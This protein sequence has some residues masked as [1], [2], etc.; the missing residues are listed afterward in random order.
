MEKQE[1]DKFK[2]EEFRYI[3]EDED[4]DVIL[5]DWRENREAKENENWGVMII[6]KADEDFAEHFKKRNYYETA[7]GSKDFQMDFYRA[8]R[9]KKDAKEYARALADVIQAVMDTAHRL[10]SQGRT[11]ASMMTIFPDSDQ[12]DLG[13][14]IGAEVTHHD[15]GSDLVRSLLNKRM[16]LHRV[17]YYGS[18][19]FDVIKGAENVSEEVIED[20][21]SRNFNAKFDMDEIQEEMEDFRETQDDR[22][23]G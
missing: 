7:T 17:E 23:G 11:T 15:Y 6:G 19:I 14:R 8:F 10:E 20:F 1:A 16:S 13:M 5:S 4:F 9:R 21:S 3:Y 22:R 18:G 12:N 2:Q